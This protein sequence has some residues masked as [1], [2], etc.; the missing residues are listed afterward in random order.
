MSSV[1]LR[2]PGNLR[3]MA[4]AKRDLEHL[5]HAASHFMRPVAHTSAPQLVESSPA[6]IMLGGPWKSREVDKIKRAWGIPWRLDALDSLAL[7]SNGGFGLFMLP[8]MQTVY[9][10]LTKAVKHREAITYLSILAQVSL[11]SQL[12]LSESLALIVDCARL[13]PL[14]ERFPGNSSSEWARVGVHAVDT[15]QART[16]DHGIGLGDEHRCVERIDEL[17]AIIGMRRVAQA[18]LDLAALRAKHTGGGELWTSS[19]D[20]ANSHASA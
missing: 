17:K 13:D 2:A 15:W 7:L 1:R 20:A 19:D 6:E 8:D 9:A 10:Y 3:A 18:E 4:K 11:H 16:I 12:T 14:Q 5:R